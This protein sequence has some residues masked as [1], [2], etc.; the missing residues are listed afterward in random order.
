M[1]YDV[2]RVEAESCDDNRHLPLDKPSI[3]S[4]N[5][6]VSALQSRAR[7]GAKQQ[8]VTASNLGLQTVLNNSDT[9][10]ILQQK[11]IE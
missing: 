4:A 3:I 6:K 2:K 10:S 8:T 1:V 9:A 5:F 11:T 7:N